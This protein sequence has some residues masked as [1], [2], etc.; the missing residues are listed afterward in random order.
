MKK[1]LSLFLILAL[2]LPSM[3][4]CS[5]TTGENETKDEAP[6]QPSVVDTTEESEKPDRFADVNYNGKSFRILTSVDTSDATNG[7]QFI[8][9]TGEQIGEIV[10]DAVY[11]RNL[12]VSEKLGISLEFTE[13]NYNYDSVKS[14]ISNLIMAGVD[15]YDIMANDLRAFASLSAEGKLHN[16]A[17]T[18][19]LDLNQSYWYKDAMEDLVFVPGGMYCLI[20]DYFTDSLASCHVLYVNESMLE[21]HFG[22]TEYINTKVFEGN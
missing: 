6:S 19:I 7:D 1:T 18:D 8:R 2:L 9:G 12:Y 15:A 14:E 21:N 10:N 13:A 5:E 11:D 3:Y 4:S 17:N 22:S 16:V 20:G